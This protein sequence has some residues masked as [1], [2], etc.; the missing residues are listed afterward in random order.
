MEI[1]R[2][3]VINDWGL[4]IAFN[5]PEIG[6]APFKSD[7]SA[8]APGS[9]NY[10]I[11]TMRLAEDTIV[12]G[13]VLDLSVQIFGEN[14]AYLFTEIFFQ[15]KEYYYGPVTQEYVST[16]DEKEIHG[17]LH[18]VWESEI[19]LTLEIT[20][21]LRILTNGEAAAFAFMQTVGYGQEV[22]QLEGLYTKKDSGNSNRARLKFDA[23][24]ELTDKRVIQEKRGR[25][26]SHELAIKTGD[27]FIPAVQVMTDQNLSNPRMHTIHGLSDTLVKTEEPFHWV[28][29]SAIPGDYLLGLV[30]EDFN[31]DQTRHF[32]PFT[33]K[34]E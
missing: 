15:D 12:P 19:N 2:N 3:F 29:E 17:V 25:L 16:K 26:V 13:E 8:G 6:S 11:N 18:P 1:V 28:D 22:Y 9:G 33:I 20:P 32:V 23:S 30:I 14:I 21:T 4:K 27:L 10:R 34:R 24:G 7:N 5:E 31:G